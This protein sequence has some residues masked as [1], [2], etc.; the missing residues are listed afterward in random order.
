MRL[1]VDDSLIKKKIE[2]LL[3]NERNEIIPTTSMHARG[4]IDTLT[5]HKTSFR[6][7]DDKVILSAAKVEQVPLLTF[8]KELLSECKKEGVDT[9][10]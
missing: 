1:G 8:D 9:L 6:H 10:P 7:F 3:N 5:R 4:A 2:E